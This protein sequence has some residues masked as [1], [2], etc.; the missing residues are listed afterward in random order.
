MP[1]SSAKNLPE[2]ARLAHE[3]EGAEE[4]GARVENQAR[5]VVGKDADPQEV[6]DEGLLEEDVLQQGDRA[7]TRRYRDPGG[8]ARLL[9]PP[10]LAVVKRAL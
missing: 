1:R 6:G 2:Q 3:A 8:N 4:L 10:L 7:T 5:E 9:C